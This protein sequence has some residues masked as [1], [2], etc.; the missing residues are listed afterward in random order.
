MPSSKETAQTNRRF[1]GF[2]NTL[3]LWNGDLEGLQGYEFN[4]R[5]TC[6]YPEIDSTKHIRLGKLVERFVVF[7]LKQDTSIEVLASNI[8]IFR[9]QITIGEL[10]C[11]IRQDEVD[12]HLEIVY[13]FYLYDPTIDNELDR[14][15]GPNRK[16][17]LILKINKLKE[18]QLPL[19]H[20]PEV[21]KDLNRLHILAKDCKQKVCFRAQLFIPLGV[22][23]ISV[24]YLNTDCICGFYIRYR[25]I[26]T[27]ESNTFFIPS[28]LDWL[29]DPHLDA[30]W[31]SADIFQ[32]EISVLLEKLKS[33]LCWMK[34]PKGNLQK[35]F[36]VWW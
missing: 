33:P 1:D 20:F 24:P 31:I 19:L 36:V 17:S 8:Q 21:T 15:I 27:F 11:L 22:S 26:I 32:N 10:D 3:S 16:D 6:Q 35:F 29:I 12:I 30:Q 5:V 4:N 2:R 28:K 14:W 34:S 9:N 18:K 25:D 23:K 7:L 13:K